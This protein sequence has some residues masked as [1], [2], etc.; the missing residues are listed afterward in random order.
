MKFGKFLD[1]AIASVGIFSMLIPGFSAWIDPTQRDKVIS[2]FNADRRNSQIFNLENEVTLSF[3]CY[4]LAK[5]L[6]LDI[7]LNDFSK[8]SSQAFLEEHIDEYM[9]HESRLFSNGN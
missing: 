2:F 4:C 7:N 8:D 5:E 9:A 6:R 3:I 1:S